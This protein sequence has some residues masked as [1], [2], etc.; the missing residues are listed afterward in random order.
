MARKSQCSFTSNPAIA[1][2]EGSTRGISV[3]NADVV[4]KEVHKEVHKNVARM[5]SKAILDKVSRIPLDGLP[6][7]KG[8]FD[9]LYAAFLQR[10]VD[11]TPLKSKVQSKLDKA[12]HWLNIKGAHYEAK[13]V[14][15]KQG[16]IDILNATE[17]MNTAMKANLEKTEAYV[18][19]SFKDLKNFQ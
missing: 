6:S 9:S 17:V 15:L 8:D 14:E 16:H 5:F 10:G 13:V 11:V 2:F 18:K 4:I 1:P 12:S 3:V 7:L 19:E